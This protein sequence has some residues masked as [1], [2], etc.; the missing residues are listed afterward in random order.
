MLRVFFGHHKCASQWVTLVIE[1]MCNELG[2]KSVC[3][4]QYTIDKYGSLQKFI[5]EEKPDFLILPESTH[6]R[7]LEIKVDYK[8]FHIIRDPRD[9]IVSCYFSHK[10]SHKISRF[11]PTAE[12]REKLQ[13][14]SKEEGL[15]YEISISKVFIENIYEWNYNYDN[16]F[17]SK[18]E[19]ITNSP[20]SE[21]VNIY[22]FLDLLEENTSIVFSLMCYFNR[23]MQKLKINFFKI[24]LKK[25]TGEQLE[26]TLNEL[27]FESLKAGKNKGLGKT[28]SHYR[29]GSSGDWMNHLS[30]EQEKK[31]LNY[32]PNILDKLGYNK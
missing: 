7:T 5:D 20:K 8:G 28:S 27:S 14:L 12:H 16:I 25:Y 30:D 11:I 17:E 29:Q 4:F 18:F 2:W 10:K 22:S 6:E 24:K 3:A 1:R 26:K 21:L 23:V 31:I 9:I 19:I 13:L 32:F 15:D